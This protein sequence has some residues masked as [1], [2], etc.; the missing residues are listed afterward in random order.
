MQVSATSVRR[1]RDL[2]ICYDATCAETR[3]FYMEYLGLQCSTD[4]CRDIQLE[5]IF[6]NHLV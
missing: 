3:D 5:I 6:V 2:D 4:I 1:W